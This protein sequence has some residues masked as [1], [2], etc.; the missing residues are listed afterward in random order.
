MVIGHRG[1]Y[2]NGPENTMKCFR[3]A[4]DSQVEGI[5]FDV[6]VIDDQIL[7]TIS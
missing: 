1:G 3:G 6:S 4:I 5:E 2:I 7:R